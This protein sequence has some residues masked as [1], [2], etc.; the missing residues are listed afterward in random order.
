MRY[1]R[2]VLAI[3]I[4]LSLLSLG[5]VASLYFMITPERV[6]ERVTH[7][8]SNQF[9]IVLESAETIEIQRLPTLTITLPKATLHFAKTSSPLGTIERTSIR[10]SPLAYFAKQPRIEDISIAGLSLQLTSNDILTWANSHK[11]VR[12][13]IIS[14]ENVSVNSGTLVFLK[15]NQSHLRIDNAKFHL[16]DLSENG[17]GIAA[18][19]LIQSPD[20]TGNADAAGILDWSK[21]F[22][23]AHINN[24]TLTAQGMWQKTDMTADISISQC[25]NPLS[26]TFHLNGFKSTVNLSNSQ[27]ALLST[28]R[29]SFSEE[30]IA[31][32]SF[33]TSLL[34]PST[35]GTDQLHAQGEISYQR[36]T[37]TLSAE[38]LKINTSFVSDATSVSEENGIITGKIHWNFATSEG[39]LSLEGTFRDTPIKID[40]TITQAAT[41]VVL[42][43]SS[44]TTDISENPSE[45]S[46]NSSHPRSGDLHVISSRPFIMGE[47]TIG[48]LRANKLTDL[49]SSQSQWLSK[50]DWKLRLSIGIKDAPLGIQR[51]KGTLLVNE[52]RALFENGQV[53][54]SN[55]EL[56]LSATLAPD[57]TWSINTHWNNIDFERLLSQA[58]LQGASSGTFNAQGI[59]SSPSQTTASVILKITNGALA[60]A[61]LTKVNEI[62]LRER[63]ERLP[64]EAFLSDNYTPVDQMNLHLQYQNGLWA[65]LESTADGLLWRATFSGK[66]YSQTLNIQAKIDFLNPEEQR[67][68]SMPTAI[69]IRQQHAPS[70]IPDW[71][72]ARADANNTIGEV[73]WSLDLLKNTIT[74]EIL[75]WWE[76]KIKPTFDL[77]LSLSNWLP[78][79]DW[80]NLTYPEWMSDWFSLENKTQ[81]N[82]SS[83]PSEQLEP[84]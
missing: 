82:K 54:L 71:E 31:V 6:Q 34:L 5:L 44:N 46:N 33:S 37:N 48:Q 32:D 15:E 11:E 43:E 7:V 40:T 45:T 17:A 28:P 20:F 49:L 79:W 60:G 13:E 83:M 69:T 65:L 72:N 19:F 36:A 66:A 21:G 38:G 77:D 9:G 67:I 29:I 1:V 53:Y 41:G 50:A 23:D 80:P 35:H 25:G 58:V 56:P 24:L 61:D 47:A 30:E 10:M 64:R 57:G 26:K 16:R 2:T 68:F 18:K 84:V 4:G 59:L 51:V 78:D 75:H 81:P 8:L 27:S 62:M 42:Q 55:K 3:L 22:F 70:W 12:P 52:N 76:T 14:I 73:G 74:R 63:P 39:R